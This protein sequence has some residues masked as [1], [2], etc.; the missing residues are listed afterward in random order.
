MTLQYSRLYFN[1]SKQAKK[2]NQT[3]TAE[4]RFVLPQ[5]LIFLTLSQERLDQLHCTFASSLRT[6]E[7]F[8]KS[9]NFV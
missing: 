9:M 5:A 8:Q 7:H 4:K 1:T 2:I 6:K 3:F